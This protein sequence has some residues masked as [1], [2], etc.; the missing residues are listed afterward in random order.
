[1]TPAP[2]LSTDIQQQIAELR[3]SRPYDG[4][5]VTLR[6]SRGGWEYEGLSG[7]CTHLAAD[8]NY[9]VLVVEHDP[10]GYWPIGMEILAE[11][12]HESVPVFHDDE[13]N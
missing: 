1:M 9:M 3:A 4:R 2:I 7:I 6:E 8:R 11:L 13:G 12:D 10:E 5:R